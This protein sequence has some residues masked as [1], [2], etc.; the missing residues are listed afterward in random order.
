MVKRFKI[1][2]IRVATFLFFWGLY[3]PLASSDKG[4]KLGSLG[5]G[6][7][8]ISVLDNGHYGGAAMAQYEHGLSRALWL[9]LGISLGG[10]FNG[11]HSLAHITPTLG[12]KATLDIVKIVPWASLGIGPLLALDDESDFHW[13]PGIASAIGVDVL[14]KSNVSLGFNLSRLQGLD[15]SQT[16]LSFTYAKRCGFF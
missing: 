5:V 15:D 14:T 4:E 7:T 16:T 1:N 2:P 10:A 12:L 3:L 8:H 9:T 13:E 6:A 11:D